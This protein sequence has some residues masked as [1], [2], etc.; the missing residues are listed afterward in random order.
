MV[1]AGRLGHGSLQ[2]PAGKASA[3]DTTPTS[4]TWEQQ[5]WREK[6]RNE[7]NPCAWLFIEAP[8]TLH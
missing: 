5:L 1:V 4:Q 8:G 6:H 7:Q 2:A 3:V